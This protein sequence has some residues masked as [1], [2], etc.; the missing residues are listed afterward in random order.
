MTGKGTTLKSFFIRFGKRTYFFDVNESQ[1]GNK[2]LKIAESK[3]V[4]EGKD[5]IVNSFILFPGDV[6]GFRKNLEEAA[7][8]LTK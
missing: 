4:E 3:F 8:F 6:E 7:G 2:Y 5:R 1:K